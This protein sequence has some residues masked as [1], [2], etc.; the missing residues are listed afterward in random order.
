[1]FKKLKERNLHL[2]I[3][4]LLVGFFLGVN[5][6]FLI[7]AEE[8]VHKY[9]NYFHRVFRIVKSEYVEPPDVKS[10][11]YGSINGMLGSLDDPFTRF[12]DEDAFRELREAAS[13]RFVGVGI[14]V[15]ISNDEVVVISPIDDS[16]AMRAGI[17][18]GDVITKVN[19]TVI[20]GMRLNEVISLI[21]G[22][23]KST[24]TLQIRRAGHD[25][26]IDFKMER[27][28]ITIRNVEFGVITPNNVGYIRIRNFAVGTA[29]DVERALSSF[30]RQNIDRIIIDLR[31][32][33]GGLLS[34]A[35]EIS[36]KFVEKFNKRQTLSFR[37]FEPA[38]RGIVNNSKVEKFTEAVQCALINYSSSLTFN[39]DQIA[40]WLVMPPLRI[41]GKLEKIE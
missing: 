2:T 35:I 4:T 6:S 23:P 9:L 37:S 20:K 5:V 29:A 31:A 22:H 30:R 8:P 7:S 15:T 12:L 26:P 28:P 10:L 27:A 17:I 21:K 25:L 14:E 13:G 39:L 16:P 34:S 24:V 19:D 3:I 18:A 36:L 1:M 38:K 11:F 33:P 32:N 40:W 41:L